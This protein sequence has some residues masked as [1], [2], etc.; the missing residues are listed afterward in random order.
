MNFI[1]LTQKSYTEYVRLCNIF[2]SLCCGCIDPV[3]PLFGKS[4]AKI[5]LSHAVESIH[6]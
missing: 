6:I 3:I 1:L 2:Y 4:I 5:T